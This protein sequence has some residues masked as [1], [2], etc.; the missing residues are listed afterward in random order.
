VKISSNRF[1]SLAYFLKFTNGF[2]QL[3]FKTLSLLLRRKKVSIS[4][5]SAT[6]KSE[7]R[8]ETVT[9]IPWNC[10]FHLQRSL[11]IF[12]LPLHPLSTTS[13]IYL[14]IFIV[15]SAERCRKN[16]SVHY[17]PHLPWALVFTLSL[18]SSEPFSW[19]L[20]LPLYSSR[21][22]WRHAAAPRTTY[23]TH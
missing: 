16:T 7:A 2:L 17:F 6:L 4:D 12:I 14:F 15:S 22:P 19:H 8:I 5:F 23:S 11:F 1:R 21:T 3:K 10:H 20:P 9:E 13:R 18:S